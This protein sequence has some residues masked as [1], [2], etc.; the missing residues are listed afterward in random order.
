MFSFSTTLYPAFKGYKIATNG[1][2][3]NLAT[4]VLTLVKPDLHEAVW[5]WYEVFGLTETFIDRSIFTD[6]IF[7]QEV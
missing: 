2:Q 6:V 3:M 7:F 5:S 4:N 1:P